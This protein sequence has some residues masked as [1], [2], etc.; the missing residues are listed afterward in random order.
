M[1]AT[2]LLDALQE[3]T[4][5]ATLSG[6]LTRS[7]AD[8][9]S[10]KQL[11]AGHVLFR[12]GQPSDAF[13]VVHRGHVALD[14]T[15]PGRGPTRLLTVGPGEIVAWSA[16]VGDGRMTTSA[17]AVD[18]VEVIQ[19]S[20]AALLRRCETEP[21]LGYRVMRQLAAALAKRLLATRLQMLDLF[22][23][24]ARRDDGSPS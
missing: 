20:G 19:L 10:W 2:Q 6:E 18:D 3:S 15:L 8:G 12:E 13:Y 11:A 23:A 16:L 7:L 22:S 14:M 5:A 9:A 17:T 21:Q 4:F 24:D 1:D